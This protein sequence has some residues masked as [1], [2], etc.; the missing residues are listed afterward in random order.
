MKEFMLLIVSKTGQALNP[1]DEQTCMTEYGKWKEELGST[2][3][4]ARRLELD[5]GVL[6]NKN[7]EIVTDGPFVESKELIAGVVLVN[8]ETLEEAQKIAYSCPLIDYFDLF[9]KQVH[10]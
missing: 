1:T 7:K 5:P 10:S 4:T 2:H 3:V 9:I 6:V 8:A